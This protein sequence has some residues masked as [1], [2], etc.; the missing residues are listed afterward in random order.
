[1]E[2]L[3]PPD[4]QFRQQQNPQR[5]ASR[6]HRPDGP[7]LRCAEGPRTEDDHRE[8]QHAAQIITDAIE[9]NIRRPQRE[10]AAGKSAR[11]P[12]RLRIVSHANRLRAKQAGFQA[13]TAALSRNHA[14]GID[15]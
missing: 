7:R 8:N 6:V 10:K 2:T 1:V 3:H 9:L 13:R 4:E 15:F 11:V 14:V 12:R 5:D